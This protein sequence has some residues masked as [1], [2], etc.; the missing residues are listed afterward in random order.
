MI[1]GTETYFLW[2]KILEIATY[3]AVC[4]SNEGF[5]PILK[6]MEVMGVTIG[7]D[8]L[9]FATTNVYALSTAAPKLLKKP[10][11]LAETPDQP[12]KTSLK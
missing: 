3:A 5:E 11:Q 9:R 6:I 4:I 8:A 7:P 1:S 10:Q 12:K 2:Q